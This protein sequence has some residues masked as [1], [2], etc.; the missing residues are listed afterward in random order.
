MALGFIITRIL[1][2]NLSLYDY[3]TYSQILLLVSTVSSLTILGMMDGV[4]FFYSGE[5]DEEKRES[6][7]VT[8]FSLQCIIG[9][10]V[11]SGIMLT[12]NLI[13][14]YFDNPEIKRLLVFAAVLPVLQN[15]IGISQVLLVSVG[16]AKLLAVRNFAVSVVRLFVVLVVIFSVSDIA[17]ILFATFWL[18]F[19]QILFFWAILKKNGC[20]LKMKSFD[21]RLFRKIF[22]YCIPMA[23]FVS[24]N[25]L[26]RDIDKYLISIMTDTETLAIYTNA[27]KQLP[28]DIIMASFC[29]VLIPKITKFISEKK[30][31]ETALLYKRFL[32]ITYVSTGIL[33]GAAI[34]IA[35]ELMRLLYSDKYESGL[36][37]FIIY[38][39]VDFFR[40]T[41]IT[42]ILSAAGKTKLLMLMGVC[43]LAFNAL[44]N[45]LFYKLFGITGP[46]IATLITTVLLGI[47]ML[48]CSVEALNSGLKALFDLKHLVMFLCEGV[49]F[50]LIAVD[51]RVRLENMGI[52]SFLIMIIVAGVYCGCMALL[53]GKRLIHSLKSVNRT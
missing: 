28:F 5:T 3:G 41:N 30:F 48:K 7:V 8:I 2:E 34:S 44:T 32:E 42:L 16:K 17:V 14:R 35:P 36:I 53:N 47:I 22:Q 4:N 13:C 29:T 15:L 46:A 20:N 37:I 50:A 31:D 9:A 40:F 33:C 49:I 45:V 1:S 10:I 21:F 18:D 24:V 38:I 39:L 51:I 43:G 12:G 6:Y 23:V 11:G 27:S 26:N 19:L 25:S 52:H